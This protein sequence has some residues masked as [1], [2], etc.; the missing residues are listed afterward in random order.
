MKNDSNMRKYVYTVVLSI[1]I[2][3]AIVILAYMG[4]YGKTEILVFTFSFHFI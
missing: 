4:N 3:I 1:I 2:E